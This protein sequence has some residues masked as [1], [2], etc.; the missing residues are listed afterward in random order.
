MNLP[1]SIHAA[2]QVSEYCERRNLL[3]D[4]RR[5][6]AIVRIGEARFAAEIKRIDRFG[7][8]GAIKNAYA[9]EA[10]P[11]PLLLVAPYITP[12]AAEHCRNIESL[13]IGT[14]G[15]AFIQVPGV[16]VYIKGSQCPKSLH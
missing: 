2:F 11:H 1:S 6:D 15:N 10:L 14:A 16:F 9:H 13:F 3:V 12:K 8:L 7:A 4:E 5:V